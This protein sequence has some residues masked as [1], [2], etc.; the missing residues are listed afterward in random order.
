MLALFE[1]IIFNA[2]IFGMIGGSGY[3]YNNNHYD[4]DSP[5]NLVI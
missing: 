2:I 5:T 4:N 3:V 1:I